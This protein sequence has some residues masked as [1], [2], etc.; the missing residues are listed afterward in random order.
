LQ[1]KILRASNRHSV[2]PTSADQSDARN[3][4]SRIAL[5]VSGRSAQDFTPR[6]NCPH[7]R[8]CAN[9]YEYRFV[10]PDASEVH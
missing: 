10:H 5:G 8:L 3:A 1:G 9:L 4:E 2:R 7:R 6:H